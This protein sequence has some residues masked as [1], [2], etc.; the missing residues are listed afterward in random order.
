MQIVHKGAGAPAQEK[1]DL[2]FGST[3]RMKSDAG[4]GTHRMGTIFDGICVGIQV[5]GP[6]R[7]SLHQLSDFLFVKESSATTLVE[8]PN[9]SVHDVNANQ[10]IKV[11]NNLVHVD[12]KIVINA[13]VIA[14][15]AKRLAVLAILLSGPSHVDV[16][17]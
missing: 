6:N 10:A 7:Q 2:S 1:L 11:T 15:I 13:Q 5:K 14:R 16:M 3:G 9:W 17:D 8:D 4:A 12:N